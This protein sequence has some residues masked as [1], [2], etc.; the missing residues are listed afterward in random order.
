MPS[1]VVDESGI[2]FQMTEACT[3][4]EKPSEPSELVG[5]R[6]FGKEKSKAVTDPDNLFQVRGH[7]TQ[8]T[9]VGTAL[10]YVDGESFTGR[11]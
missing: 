7:S 5:I 6:V 3:C 8:L 1:A 2:E 10:C 11:C 4:P 9:V